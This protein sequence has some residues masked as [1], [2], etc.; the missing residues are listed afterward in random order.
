MSTR[1]GLVFLMAAGLSTAGT[2]VFTGIDTP[3]GLGSANGTNGWIQVSQTDED[4]YWYGGMSITDDGFARTVFCIDLFTDIYLGS[5]NSTTI[6][7][8]NSP[9]QLQ[10]AWVLNQEWG[11]LTT[12]PTGSGATIAETGAAMQLALWDIMQNNSA[13]LTTAPSVLGLSAAS[14]NTTATDP[15]VASLAQQWVTFS[16]GKSSVSAYVYNN[17]CVSGAPVCNVPSQTL[18]GLAVSD[19]GPGTP[20]PATVWMFLIGGALALFARYRKPRASASL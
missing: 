18:I 11:Y 9:A 17:V 1:I 14:S 6:T 5:T 7:A 2:L 13:T 19:G 16:I 20:E 3:L 4:V 12:P 8:P 15:I 10:A